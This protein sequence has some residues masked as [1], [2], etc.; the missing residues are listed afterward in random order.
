MTSRPL[1]IL[2]AMLAEASHHFGTFRLA[3]ALRTRGHHVVYLG[4]ANMASL[5][6]PQG[7]SFVPFAEDLL[8]DGQ[9]RASSPAASG[10]A[11]GLR[12][13]Q[14]K[15][16][17]AE[18][19]FAAYLDYIENGQLD[20]RLNA[21]A[22]DLLLCDPFVWYVGLRALRLGIPT[23]NLSI[24]LSLRPNSVIPPIVSWLDPAHVSPYRVRAAWSL[25][26]IRYFFEKRLASLVLGRFRAPKRM[27]HLVDVFRRVAERSDYPCRENESYWWGEMG[28]RLALPEIVLCPR[29]FQL[30]GGPDNSRR[31]LGDFLDLDR[32]EVPMSCPGQGPL[33]LVSLGTNPEFY[34][35]AARFFLSVV[36]ASRL[37]S[38]WRFVLH[39]AGHSVRNL[40]GG[41]TSNLQIRESIPQLSLLRQAAAM[42][43]HGGINS[44][45]ECIHFGVPMVIVPG[46][47]DQP[48]NAVRAAHHGLALTVRM[49]SITPASLIELVERAMLDGCI[50]QN[51]ARL[52]Q[53][54]ADENGLQQAIDFIESFPG[55]QGPL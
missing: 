48:G 12:V 47:R 22:P 31:Y 13:R 11:Q 23:I 17:A 14:K 2:F 51:A 9:A 53:A 28:P 30:P 39:V 5:V 10:F 49:V 6:E 8:P 21:C 43:T 46:L 20:E 29:A 36:A 42:V 26:R 1:T 37:R 27:H 38:D 16:Q 52:R 41:D 19:I 35:N 54:I 32:H 50:R 33:V 7:F 25:L 3:R 15:R 34:P 18:Q 55:S 44:I 24:I 4:L 45:M 40:L